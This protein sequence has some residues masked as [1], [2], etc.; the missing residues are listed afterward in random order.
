MKI[1]SIAEIGYIRDV[2]WI[3]ESLNECY[4]DYV[5][6]ALIRGKTRWQL[7]SGETQM[8]ASTGYGLNEDSLT[9]TVFGRLAYLPASIWWQ[10]FKKA[11]HSFS[12]L[13]DDVGELEDIQFWPWWKVR[14]EAVTH[15]GQS[16]VQPDVYLR[17]SQLSVLVEAKRYDGAEMQYGKQLAAEY[18]AWSGSDENDRDAPCIVLA[19]GGHKTVDGR[20]YHEMQKNLSRLDSDLRPPILA[21]VEWTGILTEL[22]RLQESRTHP[23][24]CS[25]RIVDDLVAALEFYHV[26]PRFWLIDLPEKTQSCRPIRDFS[27]GMLRELCGHSAEGLWLKDL[28]SPTPI[29]TSIIELF[30]KRR[31]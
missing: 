8:P 14:P 26:Y 4:R 23:D 25:D 17:F 18:V 2:K 3:G 12:V 1:G 6:K 15:F 11:A 19:I 29:R 24:Y 9:A 21:S 16:H 5:L 13:P 27:I 31:T 22:L 20:L 7:D 10:V 28:S 30:L